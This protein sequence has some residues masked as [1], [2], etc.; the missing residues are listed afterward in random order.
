MKLTPNDIAGVENK[1]QENQK[2][3]NSGSKNLQKSDFQDDIEDE[4][5]KEEET[6]ASYNPNWTLR[7]CCSKLIDKLSN[8]YSLKVYE[9][10]KPF[11]ENDMQH[12]DWIIK[13]KSILTLGAIGIGCYSLL[14]PHLSILISFLIKELQHPNKL[15]RAI[16]CWTLSRFTKFILIDNLS[17][18]SNQL[19]KEYLCEILKKFLD[20][21]IIVQ[22]A[23]CTAF[24]SMVVSKKDKLEP[25]LFDIFKII[26]GV[27]NKY[28]GTS[29]LTLYDIISL[30][31]KYFAEH[32]QNQNLIEEMVNCVVKRW[33]EMVKSQEFKNISP[34]FEMVSS[35]IKV[36]EKY[37]EKFFE[38]FMNGSIII[39]EYHYNSY[40]CNNLDSNFLDRDLISKSLDL[41]SVL[42]QIFPNKVK[43]CQIKIKIMEYFFKLIETNEIYLKHYLIA[44]IGDLCKADDTII[45]TQFDKVM[46]VLFNSLEFP[47]GNKIENLEMERLSECN[48]ACWTTG[49]LALSFPVHIRVY[50]N[51]LLKKVLKILS[52]P[53]VNYYLILS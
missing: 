41:I 9:I 36:S 18:S 40:I 34:L 21:E 15:V 31:T 43:V 38:Y 4:D 49:Q 26:A 32:F 22:E 52:L 51:A 14:K 53:R 11:L 44:L 24:S 20:S 47:E 35:I 6:G 1:T 28:T 30:L 5:D 12:S 48:N 16:S 10:V 39:I 2:S 33:Y 29:L 3:S 8:L 7:K 37:I 25:F 27:F 50:V 19:F 46:N 42:C 13:E 17:D 45:P 23:A